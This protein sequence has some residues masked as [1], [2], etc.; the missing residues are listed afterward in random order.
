MMI[1][2]NK[3]TNLKLTPKH[4]PETWPENMTSKHDP[5]TLALNITQKM[6]A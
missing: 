1:P 3:K 6:T 4:G 5:Q 2:K